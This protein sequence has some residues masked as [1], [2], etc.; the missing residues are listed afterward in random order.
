MCFRLFRR[1]VLQG[2]TQPRMKID[3]PINRLEQIVRPSAAEL[4]F[5]HHLIYLAEFCRF[6]PTTHRIV[7][8]AYRSCSSAHAVIAKECENSHSEYVP[9]LQPATRAT[10]FYFLF[11]IRKWESCSRRVVWYQHNFTV[12]VHSTVALYIV[13]SDCWLGPL[14]C[15]YFRQTQPV[16]V[17]MS[18][19]DTTCSALR[20]QT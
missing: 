7:S 19:V 16:A 11:V 9:K 17:I 20:E 8:I 13:R 14:P 2:R 4:R 5:L 15:K 3:A 12:S 10:R 6:F 1:Y 18:R